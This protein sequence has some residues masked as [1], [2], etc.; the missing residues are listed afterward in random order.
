MPMN[1]VSQHLAKSF[2]FVAMQVSRSLHV[3]GSPLRS[4][5][6]KE[7]FVEFDSCRAEVMC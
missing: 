1:N 7:D 4:N 5:I 6:T 2:V 3:L